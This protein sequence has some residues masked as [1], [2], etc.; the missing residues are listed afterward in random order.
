MLEEKLSEDDVDDVDV[1]RIMMKKRSC[2]WVCGCS[3]D[4]RAQSDVGNRKMM[5]LELSQAMLQVESVSNGPISMNSNA[6]ISDF[7]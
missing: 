7:S 5:M 4:H 3:R 1:L 6:S 2:W